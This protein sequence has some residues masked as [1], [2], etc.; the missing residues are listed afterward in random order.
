MNK[1]STTNPLKRAALIL[2]LTIIAVGNATAQNLLN[3]I[4][5]NPT[6]DGNIVS[7]SL[8]NLF[9]NNN[10]TRV[11]V[12]YHSSP[13]EIFTLEFETTELIC[14]TTYYFD[15]H[16][17]DYSNYPRSWWF[18]AKQ[19][20]SDN[21]VF[22]AD[23]Q[24]TDVLTDQP[25]YA[26]FPLTESTGQYYK[27]FRIMFFA[28]SPSRRNA[29]LA[30]IKFRAYQAYDL[31]LEQC[32]VG[33]LNQM[34]SGNYLYSGSALSLSSPNVFISS[35][36]DNIQLVEGLHYNLI[37]TNGN[38]E[39]V[40][41]AVE[42][43]NYTY[44][45]TAISPCTG[46]KQF[47]FTIIQPWEG[48]GTNSNPYLIYN[49][50]DFELLKQYVNS[51]EYNMNGVHFRLM[52]DLAYDPNT[53]NNYTTLGT[54]AKRF[55]GYL[56][57]YS[58]TI[59]GI[60][61]NGSGSC[62][63]LFGG[64]QGYVNDITLTD[65]QITGGEKVGAFVGDCLNGT[66]QG[67]HV[68]NSVTINGSNYVGG[69]V[70][71]CSGSTIQNCNGPI[72]VVG[73]GNYVGGIV[74]AS[75]GSTVKNLTLDGAQVTGNECVGGIV[76]NKTNGNVE[77]CHVTNSVSLNGSN[78]VG[79]IVGANNGGTIQNCDGPATIVVS[80]NY[81]GGIAGANNGGTVKNLTLEGAQVTGNQRVGGIVGDNTSGTVEN[82]Q[83]TGSVTVSAAHHMGGI[84]GWNDQATVRNCS[85]SATVNG[86][87]TRVAGIVGTNR[88]GT[89]VGC[90]LNDAQVTGSSRVGG[91]V[92]DNYDYNDAVS[93]VEDCHVSG[94][95][96]LSGNSHVGGIVGWKDGGNVKDCT[97]IA[98]TVASGGGALIGANN[99]GTLQHNYY[100]NCTVGNATANVGTSGGDTDGARRALPII[101][102]AT[103]SYDQSSADGIVI[104]EQLYA[105]AS[106]SL[107]LIANEPVGQFY[108]YTC[109]A[110]TITQDGYN[111]YT[112]AIAAGA[113][114]TVTVTP[115][116]TTVYW[117]ID[118]GADGSAEHPYIITTTEE[119]DYLA[120]R[121]NVFG[122]HFADKYFKLGNDLAYDPNNL[123][124]DHDGDG[125]N[126]SN[127][128]AIG[129]N[130]SNM[131]QTP[132]NYFS[133]HFDGCG[134]TISGIRL[135]SPNFHLGVFGCIKG[136]ETS[137]PEVKNLTL[138]NSEINAKG[139]VGS[140]VGNN[141]CYSYHDI[142]S[143]SIIRIN[144]GFVTNCHAT[145]TV[146][147]YAVPYTGYLNSYFGGI[148]GQNYGTITYC[149]SSAIFNLGVENLSS[150]GGIVGANTGYGTNIVSYC[151]SSVTFI[152]DTSIADW[153]TQVGGIVGQNGNNKSGT[154]VVSN[155]LAIG[156]NITTPSTLTDYGGIA[157]IVGSNRST[158]ILDHNYYYECSVDGETAN[159]GYG[160]YYYD[161]NLDQ[162]I[163]Y[164][165]D[166][167]ENDGAVPLDGIL[168]N[169]DGT[170]NTDTALFGRTLYKDGKWN[171]LCLP[172][173]VSNFD[174]T[175]LED[176]DVRELE[177]A[178]LAD[179]IVTLNFGEP[180][181]SIDTG[182]P[183]IVRWAAGGTD[184]LS[185]V[186][187]AVTITTTEPQTVSFLDGAVSFIGNF[188]P[189]ADT[190]GLLL[191]AHNANNGAF[192]AAL[193]VPEGCEVVYHFPSNCIAPYGFEADNV[194]ATAADLHW[195][196][197]MPADSYTVRYRT[198]EVPSLL[199]PDFTYDLDDW[200]LR[201][202]GGNTYFDHS[203]VLFYTVTPLQPQYLISPL[204]NVETDGLTLQF[205]N[206]PLLWNPTTI[207][208][209]QIGFSSTD[210][211]TE[212]FTFGE[213]TT[214]TQGEN[215]WYL[216]SVP[217]PAG[218]RYICWKVLQ[219]VGV[220]EIA[221]ITLGEYTPAGFDE[222]VLTQGFEN[223]F[224]DWL[225]DGG[226]WGGL[227]N[228]GF[229]S[230]HS[231]NNYINISDNGYLI[232]PMLE[233][234]EGLGVD[235]YYKSSQFHIGFSS[236]DTELDSF[237]FDTISSTSSG[238]FWRHYS[239]SIPD[240]TKYIC[241]KNGNFDDIRI[242]REAWSVLPVEGEG[243]HVSTT[244]NGTEVNTA[245]TGLTPGTGYELQLKSDCDDA[246]WSEMISITTN[247]IDLTGDTLIIYTATAWNLFCDALQDNDTYNRFI[248][249]TVK[250]GADISVTRMAGSDYHDFM[251]T[252]DGQGHT[253][254]VAYGT[255][256]DPVSEEYAAPFR[257][258]ENG[259]N[260]RNLHV[261]GHIYT[262]N[263]FAGGI[264]GNQW[265]TVSVSNCRSSVIIHS[266]KEGDGTHGG[267]V[268]NQR[269]GTLTLSGCV[270]D[271]RLLTTN[272]TTLCGGFVGWRAGTCTISDCLYAPATDVTLAE[273]ETYI[274]NGATFC[275]N[276]SGTPANCYYTETL[277]TAQGKLA[278]SITSEDV[279]LAFAGETT[280]YDVSGLTT[281]GTG[282]Q[283]GNILYAGYG[284]EVNL[285]LM[286]TAG[287]SVGTV[288]YT[289][290]GGTATELT[291]V[292]GVYS[293]TMPNADVVIDA[294]TEYL[295]YNATEWDNFCDALQDNATYNRFIGKTMKLCADISVTRM[296]GSDYHDFMGTFDGQGHTLTIAYGS[297][298]NPISEEYAAPFRNL[299]N[300]AVIHS[301]HVDGHIY[302]SNKFASGLAGCQYGTVSISN[303]RSSVVIHSSKSGDGTHGGI[304]AVHHGTLTVS[305]CVF[306]GR[307]LTT[308]GT[309][310]C[311][312][313][314]GWR[315]GTC[316][317]SDCLYAPATD[318]TLAPGETYI[319]NGAT[320]CRNY[321]E[322]ALD[323]CYY[324]EALG[325]AQG[326]PAVSDPAIT[327]YG[328]PT[329][330]Y[331]VS[332]LT[333]YVNGLLHGEVFYYNPD[334]NF[335]R[336]I[337]GYG[338]GNG[339]WQLIA[340]PVLEAVTPS[341][342]N[343]FLT[344]A[345]DLYAFEPNPSD[346]LEWRNYETDT[347]NLEAG[348]GYL[349]ANSDTVTLVFSG[350]PYSG[351]GE[352]ALVYDATDD[353][354]C[355]NLVGN[356]FPYAAYLDRPYYLLDAN[357]TGIDPEPIPATTPILPC[358]AVFV[359]AVAAG[360]TAVFSVTAP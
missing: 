173:G 10:E 251:G 32:Y 301:L 268:A 329:G 284:E 227:Q 127:Y 269:G 53:P 230:A 80:G 193:Q 308:N 198:A 258:V 61:I 293:F 41:E 158:G 149:T 112:L 314:V 82:C 197:P 244:L 88:G 280:E 226:S 29:A 216:Y 57:G 145:N 334:R 28:D 207:T 89:V 48:A 278:H 261:D 327:P 276:Y 17:G 345:Y 98:A 83:A 355:W 147:I 178:T 263:K 264:L 205:Y 305:G 360:D 157:A 321:T 38:G 270:Y 326:Y 129:G 274:T 60:R 316:T 13:D 86:T 259:A 131:D 176:A 84:V 196:I 113:S 338:T 277:S 171:T 119:M 8:T 144:C 59:S 339:G 121:V 256:E 352:V 137:T 70:G 225:F 333:A 231:G 6:C 217:V 161:T 156:I 192:H 347:F 255:A 40:S 166:Q 341:A 236:T 233:E 23:M 75:N 25:H 87:N 51:G 218:T 353:R 134:H 100:L 117:N 175:P 39:V 283:Y 359:K 337:A 160:I 300:G 285:N 73:S 349:Y 46:S 237:T 11:V 54:E 152:F 199:E 260:I 106:E 44:T 7:G 271:G 311:G 126:E 124:I 194:T 324:T 219:Q 223:D 24:Y 67:C 190:T 357:G 295:I 189:F 313:L 146:A 15:A 19:N 306:D 206:K 143:H 222:A 71:T 52:N 286:A 253:L 210:N 351:N 315:Y 282:L 65:T 342:G 69:F 317:I 234:T 242:Y 9:D 330:T 245:L 108:E 78:Y 292:N 64:F 104:E 12:E 257:N 319:T 320:F 168:L 140:I 243:P 331:P 290:E 123:T 346:N 212:S 336:V 4:Y 125:I 148:V 221:R 18:F 77:N 241:L 220:L 139:N 103:L 109:N 130:S 154:G 239:T 81:V 235:F 248:G 188:V 281:C 155:C 247:N 291:P 92:G 298:E 74:G 133:G 238:N 174:G 30:E 184:I 354:K 323:N 307:L 209:F 138:D 266:S 96:T 21:W 91:I 150:V 191:D 27:Y 49:I 228:S 275:R 95:V 110:G 246:E 172:F 62:L 350:T 5:T 304:V 135:Y 254:T 120:T 101:L 288:T 122:D 16:G 312:G 159:I 169:D 85:S 240:G 273:D 43:G 128:T 208:T 343:G 163:I 136:T 50:D 3:G 214:Y 47:P 294:V 118:H 34:P 33:N 296:A 186:F 182:T 303:C 215:Q 335:T 289:P 56:H 26:E 162:Y 183:Y 2:L 279:T 72:T 358:T 79:G 116:I 94:T 1:S 309:T 14:P 250:L 267:I 151:T 37:L 114:T 66:V 35:S 328:E 325:T 111:T 224:D 201:D 356:P 141:N 229:L 167:P 164:L 58:H 297:A 310:L 299:E 265:G 332:G 165:G 318:V 170:G 102:P 97:V 179:G 99:A 200:T 42:P 340:S 249:K 344:N 107:S 302:T 93:T 63:G 36:P 20:A 45:I 348:K 177:S 187:S 22:I 252:F 132:D 287:F 180:V 142:V 90:S 204:L 153:L 68:T 195:N 213:E 272:G 181:T 105:G 203:T 322:G 115:N 185:P 232:S 76:G 31:S 262:S 211:A 202:C 55:F